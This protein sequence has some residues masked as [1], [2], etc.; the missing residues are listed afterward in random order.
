M[1]RALAYRNPDVPAKFRERWAVSADEA[2][3]L[4]TE[5]KRVLFVKY[6]SEDRGRHFVLDHA[7]RAVDE[8]WHTFLLFT[9]EYAAYCD[10]VFGRFLHHHPTTPA[11]HERAREELRSNPDAVRRVTEKS[12]WQWRLVTELA[13]EATLLKWYV[14]LPLRYGADFFR[15]APIPLEMSYAPPPSLIGQ[16]PRAARTPARAA[17]IARRPARRTT[18]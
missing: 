18:R 5:C 10:R 4:F 8:M 13:G 3:E 17:R 12:V 9:E 7:L 11:D 15:T 1:A 2:D 14:E 16:R 6:V